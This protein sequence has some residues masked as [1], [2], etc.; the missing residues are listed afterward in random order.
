MKVEVK[1]KRNSDEAIIP[2]KINTLA[3]GFDLFSPIDVEIAPNKQTCLPI[4]ISL[5]FPPG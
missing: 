3:T 2:R 4:G 5:Y 1:V